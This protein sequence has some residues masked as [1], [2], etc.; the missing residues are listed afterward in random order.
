MRSPDPRLA[1]LELLRCA[2]LEASR[3]VGTWT[4]A[5]LCSGAAGVD[6]RASHRL[7]FA[8]VVAMR[9]CLCTCRALSRCRTQ[10][11]DGG[12]GVCDRSSRRN[13]SR[14][15]SFA[16]D[17][18]CLSVTF[19]RIFSCFLGP[20]IPHRAVCAI[21]QGPFGSLV[22]SPGPIRLAIRVTA[23]ATRSPAVHTRSASVGCS[24]D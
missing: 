17:W 16:R 21:A 19:D 10:R 9:A 24:V 18:P 11:R 6:E 3:A 22:C 15:P 7:C 2:A 12:R 1:R 14:P 23:G 8:E 13:R 4:D 20:R 5:S